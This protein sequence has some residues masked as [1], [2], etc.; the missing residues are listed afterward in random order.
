MNIR[1]FFRRR[2]SDQELAHEIAAHLAAEREENQ[3]RGMNE[4]EAARRA[5]I[6]FGPTRR[7]HESLWQQNSLSWLEG[8]LRD[9]R[10]ALRTLSRTPA[11]A[12]SAMSVI[13]LGIGVTTA[14]FTIVR[15]VL[16]N[17]LPYPQSSRLVQ[18]YEDESD[19]RQD[20]HYLPVTGGAFAVWQAAAGP[21]AAM[22]FENPWQIYTLSS[23]NGQLPES[24]DA[25]WCSWNLFRVLGVAPELGRDFL[26]ADDQPGSQATVILSHALWRRRFAG[27]PA[28][29]GQSVRLNAK[30]YTVLGVMPASF[31]Y[32]NA[33]I[34]FWTPAGHE[35]T[36]EQLRTF[37]SHQFLAI[38]R[39]APGVM[40]AGLVSRLDAVQ[41]QI[42][43]VHPSPAVH[44]RVV[45][46]TLLDATVYDFK[47]PLY[48]L[49][50]AAF[51]VL[52]ISCLNV[53]NLLV[54]RSA[55]R[56]KDLAVRTALGGSRSRLLREQV[57]ESLV[58]GAGG[59]T[60]GLI[61]A[62][63]AL[64][65]LSHSGDALVRVQEIRLNAGGVAFAAILSTMTGFLAGLISALGLRS[66][67]LIESLQSSSRAHSA[68]RGR[69][70]LR[71]ALLA[72]EVGLT[73]VLLVAAGLLVKS[74]QRLRSTDVGCTV[75][76]VLTMI[77]NLP[78]L[79]YG[80]PSQ[81]VAFSE[82]LLARV[83]TLPG[84]QSAG[85]ATA[86]P[87]LG[88]G[89]DNN[90]A[91]AEHPRPPESLW[92]D[93]LRRE[94]DPGFL[95]AVQIP[96][97]RGRSFSREER[98]DR[99]QVAII[100]QSIAKQYFPGEDP[101]GRHLLL[102]D[103]ESAYEIVG[104]VGNTRFVVTQRARPT[105]YTPLFAGRSGWMTLAVRG[106]GDVEALALPI[107][108]IISVLD[109]DLA[110]AD[111][112]T[113]QQGIGAF[114]AQNE[115]T[116][117]LV[118]TFSLIALVLAA[119]GLYGVLAF[120]VTQRTSELGI[121]IALGAQ[122]AE[123]LRLTLTDGLAP[124]LVGL[125]AG[126]AGAGAVVRLLREML[127]GMNPFDWSIFSAVV[128]VLCAT[129]AAACAL[130]AWRASRL[131]PVECLRAE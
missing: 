98:L 129:A 13:A 130:P 75:D 18:L 100:D 63:G 38:A 65:L 52:A 5:L 35:A 125:A 53:A 106:R 20:F 11:F 62:T 26:A 51:C 25:A 23:A 47:T 37:E 67:Q 90:V 56:R 79:R 66:G 60:L 115:L 127:Y 70:R 71:K 9:L 101:I 121:R 16:L 3:Y 86:V 94:I 116:S 14:L 36:P 31:A 93:M 43:R 73:V 110:V 77:L 102:S 17:P 111:V 54:A 57:T 12:G 22:A 96:M 49:L 45:G 131:D 69:A 103:R 40:L 59:G 24:V 99:A 44:D 118:L 41:K 104:V 112:L 10:Y 114:T 123:I 113:L 58:L 82:E 89:D 34:Q 64:A 117:H 21:T 76:N 50:A 87:G 80:T 46:R 33:K 88:W 126:L 91:I 95:S 4:Q 48:A 108:K 83:R 109:P 128:V 92:P 27:D 72:S 85:L 19:P 97:L 6:T 8:F 55:A 32:P 74:Y 1:R 7:V 107:Q 42:K 119:V 2:R 122:R 39:L 68:G 30:P 81:R 124:V 29:V 120:L 15:S 105:F 61:L 84:V 78:E 28:I